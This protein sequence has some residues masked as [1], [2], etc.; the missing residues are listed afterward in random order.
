MMA[1]PGS[2]PRLALLQTSGFD[3]KLEK[4]YLPTPNSNSVSLVTLNY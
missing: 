4:N 3:A 2:E 1:C